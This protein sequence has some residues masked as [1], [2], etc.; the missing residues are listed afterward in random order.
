MS[1]KLSRSLTF[2]GLLGFGFNIMIGSGMFFLPGKAIGHHGA[3]LDTRCS[4]STL[5][6]GIAGFLFR[7]AQQPVHPDRWTDSLHPRDAGASS[8]VWR[9]L[10]GLPTL[11]GLES[12][13]I[14]AFV[15]LLLVINLRNVAFN[16]TDERRVAV[17]AVRR[18]DRRLPG[19]RTF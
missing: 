7:R 6:R 12:V 17:F 8:R 9:G 3:G 15:A 14:A 18:P 16:A 19:G 5:D 11:S 1:E 13:L 4:G 2:I 10:A